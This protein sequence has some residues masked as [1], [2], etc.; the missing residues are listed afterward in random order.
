M[1]D[2]I[3]REALRVAEVAKRCAE[4]RLDPVDVTRTENGS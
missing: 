2:G 3:T 4:T 1:R